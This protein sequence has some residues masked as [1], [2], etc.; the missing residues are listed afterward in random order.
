MKNYLN[1][2]NNYIIENIG[3]NLN[4]VQT[5]YLFKVTNNNELI[6]RYFYDIRGLNN[7]GVCGI[8]L[9]IIKNIFSVIYFE[10]G[11]HKICSTN[12]SNQVCDYG[13]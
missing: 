2:L 7:C 5:Y 1:I 8:D 10:K 3:K 4:K 9:E 11:F 6:N 12:C 13:V